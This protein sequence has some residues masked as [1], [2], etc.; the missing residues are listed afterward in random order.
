MSIA[1][2]LLT[3]ISQSGRNS[4]S[5]LTLSPVYATDGGAACCSMILSVLR[6][7]CCLAAGWFMYS[8]DVFMVWQKA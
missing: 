8:N 7:A 3:L 1:G 5:A 6:F 4:G 2:L